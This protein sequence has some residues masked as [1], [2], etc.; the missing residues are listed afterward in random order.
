MTTSV[1]LYL[2]TPPG[3]RSVEVARFMWQLDD[4][5]EMLREDLKGVTPAE[6]EFQPQRGMNS[7]G[8]LLAHLAIVEVFWTQLG[9]AQVP[10]D[11]TPIGLDMMGDGMPI[12]PDATPPA[13]LAGRELGYY[14]DLLARGRAVVKA[15]AQ[16][17]TD[18]DLKS[19]VNRVRKNGEQQT[20]D[21]A[22]VLY[23]LV[24][25]FAGHYGQILLLRHMY[26]AR[27]G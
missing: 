6:L 9:L 3:Y 2:E 19:R 23:H 22:W 12:A 8:M 1:E 15:A 13:H 21:K 20:F 25:H 18:A 26:R 24:E 14:E 4:L 16:T 17:L 7:I 10:E 11:W 5:L 27:S